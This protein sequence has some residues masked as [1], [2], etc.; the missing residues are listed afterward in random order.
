MRLVPAVPRAPK[1][2]MNERQAP[3]LRTQP[4]MTR[5]WISGVW[6]PGSLEAI[7][8]PEALRFPDPSLDPA[9]DM[10]A[11]PTFP[12]RA[13]TVAPVAPR[14]SGERRPGAGPP[15]G[16]RCRRARRSS[17]LSGGVCSC[18]WERGHDCSR[19]RRSDGWRIRRQF[20]GGGADLPVLRDL[21]QKVRQHWAVT[22]AAGVGF[23]RPDAARRQTDLAALGAAMGGA[24]PGK[25]L[26]H[27]AF[28]APPV[29]RSLFIRQ[30]A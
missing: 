10:T 26:I 12:E 19:Q 29:P 21:V 16:C 6:R 5:M 28:A 27:R 9:P 14:R 17:P 7:L 8:P 11:R 3:L 30:G 13:G 23:H 15:A 24:L 18:G 22:V 25:P 1:R 4:R 2:F 20:S